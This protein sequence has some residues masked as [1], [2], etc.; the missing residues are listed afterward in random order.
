M[1]ATVSYHK[2]GA[3]KKKSTNVFSYNSGGRRS[4]ISLG[5]SKSR[6][7][8]PPEAQGQIGFHAFPSSRWPLVFPGLWNLL[9]ASKP[10]AYIVSL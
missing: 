1:N 8:Q 4:A 3:F 2:F 10:A 7:R 6:C 9:L 5:G